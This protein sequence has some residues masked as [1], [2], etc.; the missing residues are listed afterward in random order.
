MT[1]RNANV[2]LAHVLILAITFA[3]GVGSVLQYMVA[4]RVNVHAGRA[5]G[6]LALSVLLAVGLYSLFVRQLKAGYTH[7]EDYSLHVC[8]LGLSCVI[9]QLLAL[10]SGGMTRIAWPFLAL[11]LQY[12]WWFAL[13]NVFVAVIV[14]LLRGRAQNEA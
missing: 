5:A 3:V 11:P 8:S 7:R 2:F 12:V 13:S 9:Y 4:H 1:H 10:I 6:V 14:R